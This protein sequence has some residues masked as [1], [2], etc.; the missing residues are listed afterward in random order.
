[1]TGRELKSA[2]LQALDVALTSATARE[3]L[4]IEE[5]E[6]SLAVTLSVL[7]ECLPTMDEQSLYEALQ[8]EGQD[9]R[10]EILSSY[11][12]LNKEHETEMEVEKAQAEFLQQCISGLN[13]TTLID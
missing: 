6:P 8:S 12:A 4:L 10:N 2:M 11:I 5:S 3:I 9:Y 1:M 13:C 7:Q